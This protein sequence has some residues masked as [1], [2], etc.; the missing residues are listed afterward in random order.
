MWCYWA[1]I[2][3]LF[4]SPNERTCCRY[5]FT[6]QMRAF[7]WQQLKNKMRACP[8]RD[9][10]GTFTQLKRKHR[11][12]KHTN[13][14][15]NFSQRPI[16]RSLLPALQ[17][18]PIFCAAAH[19]AGWWLSP[20]QLTV[21]LAYLRLAQTLT[22]VGE[23]TVYTYWCPHSYALACTFLIVK[24]LWHIREEALCTWY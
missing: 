14:F 9:A 3:L 7:T 6:W 16:C 24:Q 1:K 13:I 11:T 10:Y 2:W 4:S 19:Y 22:L 18:Q 20:C 21:Q 5:S 23:R 17:R 12:C 8:H 15:H